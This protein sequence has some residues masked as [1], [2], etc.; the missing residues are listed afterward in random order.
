[1][2]EVLQQIEPIISL[3][4]LD[5]ARNL[6]RKIHVEQRLIEFI[7]RITWETRNDRS[8]YLGASPR[9]SIALLQVSKAL[10]VLNGRD[11]VIPEDILKAVPQVLRH[12][13]NLTPEKEMEGMTTDDVLKE[14]VAR[15]EIPR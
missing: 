4:V 14:I 6:V 13:I 12:R 5:H 10:S 3:E 8:L 1:M 15:M 11:F 7:A 9:A 2:N